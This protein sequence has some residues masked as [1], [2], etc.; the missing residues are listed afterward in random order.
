MGLSNKKGQPPFSF[1]KKLR[2][3]RGMKRKSSP[4]GLQGIHPRQVVLLPINLEAQIPPKNL[5]RVVVTAI[6]TMDLS[7]LRKLS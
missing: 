6:E 5:V 3:I 1:L 2:D 7:T 4:T